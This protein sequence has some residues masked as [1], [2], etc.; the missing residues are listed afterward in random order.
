[1]S[2]TIAYLLT[3]PLM[4]AIMGLAFGFVALCNAARTEEIETRS[5]AEARHDRRNR[6][7]F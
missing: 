6:N 5:L 4:I 2:D 3:L 7:K 1:M